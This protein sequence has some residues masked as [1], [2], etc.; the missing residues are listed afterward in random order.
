MAVP[1]AKTS[2]S[3]KRM[4]RAHHHLSMPAIARCARCGKATRPHS[5][6]PSCGYYHSTQDFAE[7]DK[8]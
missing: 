5:V 1:K 8:P 2:K 3:R 6:C 4:R 7:T